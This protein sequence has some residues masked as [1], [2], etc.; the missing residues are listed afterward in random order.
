M[1][2]IVDAEEFPRRAGRGSVLAIGAATAIVLLFASTVEPVQGAARNALGLAG[3]V[4]LTVTLSGT[5]T[6]ET[7]GPIP[8]AFIRIDQGHELATT[9]SDAGGRY[10]ADFSIWTNAPAYLSVGANGYEPIMR[11]LHTSSTDPHNDVR[12]RPVVRIDAGASMHLV[13][14]ADDGLCWTVSEP[15]RAWPCRFVHVTG[16]ESGGLDVGVVPDDPRDRIGV[17]FGVGTRPQVILG[18]TCC[19]TSDSTRVTGGGEAFVQI[20]ALDFDSGGEGKPL[21]PKGFVFR[22]ALAP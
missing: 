8:H 17:S 12:L 18:E 13:V 21:A 2:R 20:V 7:G 11:D 15:R 10:E 5:I 4:P 22:T 9:I 19:G 6:D 14:T 1:S 3:L 16:L